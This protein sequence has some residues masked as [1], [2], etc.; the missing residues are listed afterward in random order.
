MF[1]PAN[2]HLLTTSVRIIKIYSSLIDV[3]NIE[4]YE[5]INV[6]ARFDEVKKS[7]NQKTKIYVS[8]KCNVW[9]VGLEKFDPRLYLA[10]F[11]TARFSS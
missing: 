7:C 5:F 8:K 11:S 10:N 3:E 9:K 4:E 6:F 2:F 1:H